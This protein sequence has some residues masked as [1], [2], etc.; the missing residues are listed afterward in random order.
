MFI[1][2]IRGLALGATAMAVIGTAVALGTRD[3]VAALFGACGVGM[4]ASIARLL[5]T[6]ANRPAAG[7]EGNPFHSLSGKLLLALLAPSSA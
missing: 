4:L 3:W 7:A 5:W 1:R 2:I 6:T